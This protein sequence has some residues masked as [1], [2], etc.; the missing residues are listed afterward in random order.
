MNELA[1]AGEEALGVKVS[2]NMVDRLN[3][4]SRAVAS[5]PCA[6]KEVLRAEDIPPPSRS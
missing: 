2:T 3:A 5:Y 1:R 4:Y 6:I